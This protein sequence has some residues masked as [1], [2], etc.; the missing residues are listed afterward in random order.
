MKMYYEWRKALRRKR[1]TWI[2]HDVG[3]WVTKKCKWLCRRVSLESENSTFT[4]NTK[5]LTSCAPTLFRPVGRFVR[6]SFTFLTKKTIGSGIRIRAEDWFYLANL[7]FHPLVGCNKKIKLGLRFCAPWKREQK[8]RPG[9][10]PKFTTVCKKN[11]QKTLNVEWKWK[12]GKCK[13]W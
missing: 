7:I 12:N 9:K 10:K 1:N 3:L 8:R 4:Q 6:S 2:T 13:S 11:R 5:T